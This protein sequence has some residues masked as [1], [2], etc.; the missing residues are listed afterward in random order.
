MTKN[1]TALICILSAISASCVIS[2]NVYYAI[3]IAITTLLVVGIV[4][5][6][7]SKDDEEED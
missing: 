5:L 1:R 2:L 6:D 4:S 3:T 7:F